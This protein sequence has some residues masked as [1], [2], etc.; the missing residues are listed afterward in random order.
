MGPNPWLNSMRPIS[1]RTLFIKALCVCVGGGGGG[2]GGY[3]W[4]T[5]HMFSVHFYKDL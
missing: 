1:C 4:E 3:D 5:K 2:G